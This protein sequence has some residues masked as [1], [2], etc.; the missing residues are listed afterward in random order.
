MPR[1]RHRSIHSMRQRCRHRGRP[2][3]LPHPP[4]NFGRNNVASRTSTP[5][6]PPPAFSPPPEATAATAKRT[7]ENVTEATAAAA[8]APG[9]LP[10]SV[11]NHARVARPDLRHD[12]I[13]T[14]STGGS[15]T[16]SPPRAGESRRRTRSTGRRL[17]G[18]SRAT[19]IAAKPAPPD[20]A[21]TDQRP[22]VSKSRRSD[23]RSPRCTAASRARRVTSGPNGRRLL[24]IPTPQHHRPR[25]VTGQASCRSTRPLGR[26]VFRSVA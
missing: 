13:L 3:G 20:R 7:S 12:V 1:R 5:I 25:R 21:S 18:S 8:A 2:S 11:V 24:R 26:P 22:R 15:S 9:A 14:E 19:S 17:R 16:P 10:S 4:S 6:M 23:P